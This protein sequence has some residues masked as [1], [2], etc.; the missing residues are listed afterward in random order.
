MVALLLLHAVAATI[1]AVLARTVG[2]RCALVA[3]LAPAAAFGWLL[4]RA[5]GVAD[6][7]T[8]ATAIEWAPSLGL[9]IDLRL[10]GL[11]LVAGL[12]VTGVGAVVL[13]YT[14]HYVTDGSDDG[15]ARLPV[16]L[17]LFAGSMLGVVLADHLLAL[18]VFWEL[19]TVCSFLL[20]GAVDAA[21]RR[22]ALQALIITSGGGFAMLL[23]LV[24]LG[25]SAGTYRISAIMANPPDG[26][27]VE[28]ALILVIVGAVAK[29]AQ[30][31]LTS[32]LPAAMAAPTPVSAYLHAAAMVKAGVYLV[33][34]FTP[35]FEH[36]TA[37]RPVVVTVGLATLVLAGA[38]A[39]GQTDLKRLLAYGTASQLGLLF[40]LL[41]AGTRTAALAGLTMF[42]AHA[43]FK[44][45]LFLVT[46]AIEHEA[47]TRDL[48]ELSSVRRTAPGLVTVA[49][50]AGVS[51][52]GL[53][54][55]VGYLGKEAAYEAFLEPYPGGAW[56]LA[57]VVGGSSLTV[58]YTLRFLWALLADRSDARVPA[59]RPGL[60]L[61]VA[62]A[63]LSVGGVVLGITA[64]FTDHLA[65]LHA[66]EYAEP[67]GSPYELALWHGWTPALALSA[68]TIV[69]GVAA[70]ALSGRL[71]P[72]IRPLAA[73]I[74]AAGRL[75]AAT[76]A[77][78][79]AV[80]AA[81][82]ATHTGS[83]PAYL[84]VVLLTT[85]VAPVAFLVAQGLPAGPFGLWDRAAQALVGLATAIACVL[86]A[87]LRSR[88]TAVLLVSAAGYLV[89][90]LFAVHG[91][92]D[93]ALTQVLVETLML[94]VILLVLRRS[95]E[96]APPSPRLTQGVRATLATLVGLAITLV[97]L[98]VTANHTPSR[99]IDEFVTA[100]EESG[101]ANIVNTILIDVRAFDT[102]GEVT[103][104]TVTATGVVS[105]VLV[106]RRTGGP[107][108]LTDDPGRE[109]QAEDAR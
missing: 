89:A 55:T 61:T 81:V 64:T 49:V 6:G 16:L 50:L 46:G 28:A 38:R 19:T 54:P 90:V 3:A 85:V 62:P 109:P 39:L 93:L 101:A 65:R 95:G 23:G 66:R 108:R 92:P 98:A 31:P 7:E 32:W 45:T 63:L 40:V 37:W 4:V 13:Q 86:A 41:G 33:A 21:R 9:V 27:L 68:G 99:V 75:S 48:R 24:M 56:V 20:I 84:A 83:V 30:V 1:T 69:L 36:S 76:T 18:Y 26:G 102:I 25:H 53:P 97:A 17:V 70:F 22:A 103:V 35:A 12:V 82:A 43:L 80:R 10:D 78:V 73:A 57:G 44:A 106:R 77:L 71:E 52:A 58:A 72:R 34:R 96:Y 79:R 2:P 60:G 51:M 11:S 94:L 87:I 88:I 67:S 91:A 104:L 8:P 29:S 105:L 5:P 47:G 14:R 42:V 100:S 15:P 107:P 59:H 74:D